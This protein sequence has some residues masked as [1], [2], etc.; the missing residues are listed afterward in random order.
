MRV[1]HI[2]LAL[3]LPATLVGQELTADQ[4]KSITVRS[5]GP[6]L[7]TGRVA[8]VKIDPNNTNV[9][10]VAA[11][12]GG[13]WKTVNRGVTFPP[14]FDDGG[15]FNNCCIVIDPKNSNVLWLGT[16]E[17]NSQRSAHFGDGV[18]KSTDA[19]KTWK[20]VGLETSE[21]IG[22]IRIDPRNSDVVYVAAQ[23]PLF[24]AGGERGLYKTT[25]GGASWEQV[26]KISENTGVT[27]V[28]LDP[29]NPDVIYAAAYPR[30]RNVGQAI[31]GSPEGGIFKS[32]NAGKSWTK[33]SKGLPTRDIGRSALAIE[34]RK[35]PTEIYAFIEAQND[36]QNCTL[37][38]FYRSTDAGASWTHF[39]KNAV[40]PAGGR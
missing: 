39:G 5:I 17:N 9:W 35:N 22:Q 32:T 29:K 8:D 24:S 36:E 40:A 14:I 12:F 23:G 18:Y 30:R 3:L 21:H 7:V 11:A 4:L 20:R 25:N 28:V 26:L 38:G 37:S 33:L 15:A 31:G 19:G 34:T 10:Y 16:G 27:D 1:R 13:V 2:A 6:G